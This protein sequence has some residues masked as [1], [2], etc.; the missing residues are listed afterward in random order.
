[1]DEARA[2]LEQILRN[3]HQLSREVRVTLGEGRIRIVVK[4]PAFPSRKTGTQFF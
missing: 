3:R 2:V 4:P 1:M